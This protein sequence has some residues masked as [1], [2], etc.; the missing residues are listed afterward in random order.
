MCFMAF[1]EQKLWILKSTPPPQSDI[2]SS[3]I[4]GQKYISGDCKKIWLSVNNAN[5]IPC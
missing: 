5:I 4:F 1:K 3:D 2:K